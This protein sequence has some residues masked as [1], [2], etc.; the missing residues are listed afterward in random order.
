M[1][2]SLVQ[3]VA[4]VACVPSLLA[5]AIAEEAD[6]KTLPTLLGSQLSSGE[7]VLGKLAGRLIDVGILLAIGVPVMGLLSL[8]GG[9]DPLLIVIGFAATCSTA[10]FVAALTMLVSVHAANGDR[11]RARAHAYI[12]LW[13]LVP[14]IVQTVPLAARFPSASRVLAELNAW[15]LPTNPIAPVWRVLLWFI[16]PMRVLNPGLINPS[17][18]TLA[19]DFARMIPYQLAFALFFI[20]VAMWRLRPSFLRR[21][22]RASRPMRRAAS[23][24]LVRRPPCGDDPML[25]KELSLDRRVHGALGTVVFALVMIALNEFASRGWLWFRMQR[26]GAEIVEF[27]VWSAWGPQGDSRAFL[28]GVIRWLTGMLGGLWMLSVAVTAAAGITSERERE[29]W[30]GLT[31][32]PL[33]AWEIIRAKLLGAVWRNRMV[34]G[35]ILV[36]WGVGI[37][38][39][40]VHPVGVLLAALALC[41]STWFAAALGTFFSSRSSATGDAI[42]RTILSLLALVAGYLV[43]FAMSDNL[44]SGLIHLFSAP[45]LIAVSLLSYRDVNFVVG[46]FSADRSPGKVLLLIALPLVALSGYGCVAWILTRAATRRLRPAEPGGLRLAPSAPRD[47]VS[48]RPSSFQ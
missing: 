44:V 40:A 30:N 21:E 16:G 32:T 42:G 17:P 22:A 38:L 48:E 6:R 26:A 10:L 28:N 2:F 34:V 47:E 12:L 13:L 7:I 19:A 31:T 35:L 14:I 27:G 11:A 5:G 29:T 24:R 18:A 9:V 8:E 41:V 15:V 46:Q 39:Q 45:S 33:S 1:A 25:W 4:V 20:L 23:R 43:M 37:A 36:L 3:M